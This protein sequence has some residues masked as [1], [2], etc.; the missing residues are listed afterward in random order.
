ELVEEHPGG[1]FPNSQWG[2][3][4]R[5]SDPDATY[6]DDFARKSAFD[7]MNQRLCGV[8]GSGAGGSPAS[9]GPT[10]SGA[11]G[12]ASNGEGPGA[13]QGSG[14]GAGDGG[15]GVHGSTGDP[16]A[17]GALPDA[18][19]GTSE[20]GCACA[21]GPSHGAPLSWL[22]AALALVLC[23]NRRKPRALVPAC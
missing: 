6:A 12:G 15:A 13:A 1:M 17:G 20:G 10:T 9:G 7:A 16:S 23:A 18:P 5:T 11:G 3:T 19:D 4:L 21:S 14:A 8:G 22:G 2:L